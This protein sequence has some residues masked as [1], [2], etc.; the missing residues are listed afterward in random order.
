MDLDPSHKPLGRS[1]F[2][3]EAEDVARELIGCFLVRKLGRRVVKSRITETEAYVGPHDLACHAARGRTM[4]T[5]PMFSRAGTLYVYLVY[6]LHWML[7]VVTGPTGYPAAVLIRSVDTI[8][9]PGRLSGALGVRGALNGL[10]ASERNGLWFIKD[11]RLAPL[12]V[13][14]TPRIGVE[15]AGPIWSVKPYRFVSI[16]GQSA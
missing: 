12:G 15:Y 1:F 14:C 10:M 9:G 4:R 7:N 8:S 5:E 16:T 3:R 2:N 6:G 11:D 13:A